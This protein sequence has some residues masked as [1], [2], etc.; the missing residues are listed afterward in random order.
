[1]LAAAPQ[2]DSRALRIRLDERPLQGAAAA[3]TLL[4]AP[5]RYRLDATLL[6]DRT[7]PEATLEWTVDCL[8]PRAQRLASAAPVA[9]AARQW[10]AFS[11]EFRV[12]DGDCVA[13]RLQLQPRAPGLR[14]AGELWFDAFTLAA[15]PTTL[16]AP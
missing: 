1:M 11:L 10:T 6:V 2:G 12:P 9:A 3:Q 15:A 5:G 13:Q 14:A 8:A 4:L 16:G 7:S